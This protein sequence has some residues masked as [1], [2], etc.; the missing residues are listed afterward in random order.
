M[1]NL[2]ESASWRALCE[3]TSCRQLIAVRLALSQWITPIDR[4]IAT[5]QKLPQNIP[6]FFI[7]VSIKIFKCKKRLKLSFFHG[8]KPW[9]IRKVKIKQKRRSLSH[10]FTKRKRNKNINAIEKNKS[11]VNFLGKL[12]RKNVLVIG[13]VTLQNHILKY[14]TQLDN[15]FYQNQYQ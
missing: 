13:I 9:I 8:D 15:T 11:Q 6:Y 4:K 3:L 2:L 12:K 10:M 14:D 1:G 7:Q 5:E